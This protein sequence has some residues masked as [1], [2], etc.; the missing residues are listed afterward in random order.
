MSFAIRNFSLTG[1]GLRS[2]SLGRRNDINAL[3]SNSGKSSST[4]TDSFSNSEA[5]YTLLGALVRC[6][7]LIRKGSLG[8]NASGRV[9]DVAVYRLP[10]DLSSHSH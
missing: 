3:A 4:P 7:P 1:P 8:G 5:I 6:V 10:R 9:S 2:S